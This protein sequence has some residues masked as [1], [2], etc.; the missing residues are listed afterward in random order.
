M[1]V[2]SDHPI[3][4]KSDKNILQWRKGE[5]EKDKNINFALENFSEHFFELISK[6]NYEGCY[7]TRLQGNDITSSNTTDLLIHASNLVHYSIAQ[8]KVT[9]TKGKPQVLLSFDVSVLALL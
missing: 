4:R 6:G 2:S 9:P 1:I 8:T 3:Q 7:F 5:L